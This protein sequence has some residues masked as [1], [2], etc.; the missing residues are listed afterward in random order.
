MY[1]GGGPEIERPIA[2]VASMVNQN[3]T[4]VREAAQRMEIA[5]V[6]RHIL[7]LVMWES[8]S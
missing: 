7:S 5:E 2:D 1:P 8:R 4:F 6:E 3:L